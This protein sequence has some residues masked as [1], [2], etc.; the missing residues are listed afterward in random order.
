MKSSFLIYICKE[1]KHCR[2]YLL[3]SS[4]KGNTPL[5]HA[6]KNGNE[7][8]VQE[9]I[10]HGADVNDKNKDGKQFSFYFPKTEKYC[11]YTFFYLNLSSS[12]LLILHK[13]ERKKT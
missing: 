8:I 5:H 2:N 13:F 3:I 12:M 1:K 11:K 10:L 4:C 6:A 9:L 7:I